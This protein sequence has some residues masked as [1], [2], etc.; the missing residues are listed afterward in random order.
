VATSRRSFIKSLFG[1]LA[2][3]YVG[4][5]KAAEPGEVFTNYSGYNI[6]GPDIGKTFTKKSFSEIIT[7]TLRERAPLVADNVLQNNALLVK[8][9]SKEYGKGAKSTRASQSTQ[10]YGGIQTWV[11][12]QRI[13]ERA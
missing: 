6:L 12:P 7:T 5:A 9:R 11:P 8:L 3:P 4:G 2:L 13:K 1:V 10:S